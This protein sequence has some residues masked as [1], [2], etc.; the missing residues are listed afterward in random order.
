MN[1]TGEEA[2]QVNINKAIVIYSDA[3]KTTHEEADNSLAQQ[4][5]IAATEN[6]NGFAVFLDDKDIYIYLTAASLCYTRKSI[7]SYHGV[8]NK[9]KDSYV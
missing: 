9:G 3:L 5:V 4:M 2:I 6:Q 7:T 8:A 1:I